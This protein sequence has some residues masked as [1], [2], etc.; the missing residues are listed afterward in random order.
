MAKTDGAALRPVPGLL[1]SQ[2]HTK[3]TGFEGCSPPFSPRYTTAYLH[4]IGMFS[5]GNQL[6]SPEHQASAVQQ[7]ESTHRII[8]IFF[9][10]KKKGNQNKLKIHMK[11][12]CYSVTRICK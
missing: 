7:R 8:I 3:D 2:L 12:P 1:S 11:T 9:F 6:K 10:Q 4:F 5:N